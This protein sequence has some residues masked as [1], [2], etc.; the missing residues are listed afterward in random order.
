MTEPRT[1]AAI[2]RAAIR[3]ACNLPETVTVHPFYISVPDAETLAQ[4]A[5]RLPQ[6]KTYLKFSPDDWNNDHE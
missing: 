2:A 5:D 6:R 3:R 4:I 1:P